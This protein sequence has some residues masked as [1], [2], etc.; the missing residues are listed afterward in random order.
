MN[1][2]LTGWFAAWAL[3]ALLGAAGCDSEGGKSCLFLGLFVS[4]GTVFVIGACHLLN[5][6]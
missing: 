4:I 5:V 6:L 2:F 1:T 3:L